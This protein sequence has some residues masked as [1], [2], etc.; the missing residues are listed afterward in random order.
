MDYQTFEPYL[1]LKDFVK[2]F[3]TLKSSVDERPEKQSIVPDG[4]M[5]MIFHDGDL[6]KQYTDDGKS[7]VQPRCF[8]IGQLTRP[9]EIEPTGQTGIFSVRFHPNGFE[10]FAILPIKEMENRAISLE[11]LFGKEGKDLGAKIINAQSVEEKIDIV[12][13]FLLNSLNSPE[14]IDC[15]VRSAVETILAGQEQISS[16]LFSF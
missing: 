1:I 12:E 8:V 11:A 3:W 2:C 16:I 9:L 14:T 4:C 5:E 10:P 13:I 6:Y 7:T 15:I